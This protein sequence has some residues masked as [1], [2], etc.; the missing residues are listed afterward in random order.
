VRSTLA[1]EVGDAESLARVGAEVAVAGFFRDQRPL[2]GGAGLADWRLCGFLSRLLLTER[3]TGDAGEA[4]LA[5]TH[6]RL[7]AERLLLVGLGAR[8]RFGADAH[9][10]AVEAAM[11]RLL[12]L[13]AAS[14]VVD[15]P[16]PA[17]EASAELLAE[18]Y[19][20]GSCAVLDARPARFLLR[21]VAPPGSAGRIRQALEQA[22]VSH[23]RGATSL[24]LIRP[25]LPGA[26]AGNA[27][28]GASARSGAP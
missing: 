2:R 11:H 18:S 7:R 19:V 6:G 5:T 12:D 15:L 26:A 20:E 23:P 16:A 21:V 28:T 8:Q 22:A 13:G 27:S 3:A 24:R 14:A 1:L 9:R 25:P 4:V 17:G 10:A